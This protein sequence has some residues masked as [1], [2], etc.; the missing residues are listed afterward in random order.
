MT[1]FIKTLYTENKRLRNT[2]P[3]EKRGGGVNNS[4]LIDDNRCVNAR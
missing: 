1:I 3:T 4:G 2:N